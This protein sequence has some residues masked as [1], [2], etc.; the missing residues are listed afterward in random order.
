MPTRS[1]SAK[2]DGTLKEGS[3]RIEMAT[4]AW[5]GPYSWSS[6]FEEAQGTN[7]EELIAAA[8][9]GCF[10]M[11]FAGDLGAAGFDPTSVR[12]TANVRLEK[13]EAGWNIVAIELDSEVQ[14]DGID[15]ARFQEIAEQ[16]K[17]ACPVS[18]ALA[19]VPVITVNAK[20][21]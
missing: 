15:D 17:A 16:A 4:G 18:K 19:A 13:G 3:G 14:V 21:V 5:E 20:R 9:A 1:A 8:H 10:S 11:K 7:P 12:T 2:W 6:R